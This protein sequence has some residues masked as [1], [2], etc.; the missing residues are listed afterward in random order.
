[1]DFEKPRTT[2]TFE[3]QSINYTT[4]PTYALNRVSG[5]PS[6]GILQLIP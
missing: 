1:M 4:G 5:S 3:N 6:I 2:K